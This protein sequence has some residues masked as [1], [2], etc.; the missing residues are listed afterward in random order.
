MPTNHDE[1]DPSARVRGA[2]VASDR[3]GPHSPSRTPARCSFAFAAVGR[4]SPRLVSAHRLRRAARLRAAPSRCPPFLAANVSGVVEAVGADV[5]GFA[6][7]DEVFGMIRF[8]SFGESAAHCRIRRRSRVGPRT[9]AGEHRSHSRRGRA[10]GGPHRV[11][12]PHRAR[13][14]RAESIPIHTASPH[15]PWRRHHRA[16]Q[17][18]RRRRRPLRGA[19]RQMER[20]TCDCRGIERPRIVPAQP[21]RRRIHRLHQ[22]Q[23]G[24]RRP[25]HRPRP[26]HPRRPHQ[27]SL[28]AHLETRRCALPGLP[29]QHRQG[30]S[31]EARRHHIDDPGALQWRAAR[32]ARTLARRRHGARRDRQHVSP[33]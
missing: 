31:E 29:Q 13:T 33:R 7:G 6:V 21:R 26:R 16:R 19:A 32:R 14:R 11:A 18:G 24:R 2:R 30:R 1:G 10:D 27:R 4:E 17:W 25:R 23:A 9:Q 5:R 3:R 28:P 15:G 22:S 20:R 12:V 8:P